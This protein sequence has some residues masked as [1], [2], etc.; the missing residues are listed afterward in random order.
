MKSWASPDIVVV[1]TLTGI[2]QTASWSS[3]NILINKYI[4]CP[5]RIYVYLQS[6]YTQLQGLTLCLRSFMASIIG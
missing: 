1:S 5:D 3:W 6:L 4:I 2:N